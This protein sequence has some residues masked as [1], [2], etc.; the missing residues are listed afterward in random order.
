VPGKGSLGVGCLLAGMLLSGTSAHAQDA[1]VSALGL[2]SALGHNNGLNNPPG[3]L[4]P[5]QSHLGPVDFTLGA[6]AGVQANDNINLTQNDAQPDTII[7]AGMYLN[8]VWAAAE[9][10]ELSFNISAGYA[11]YLA[12]P[13][14]DQASI[15]PGSVLSWK[16]SFE[17]GSLTFFDQFSDSQAVIT[18]ASVSGVGTLPRIDNTIGT[19]AEWQPGRWLFDLGYSH[20]NFFSDDAAYQYLNR[21]SEYFFL[22]G[23][24]RLVEDTQLGLEASAGF[25]TYEQAIQSNNRNFSAG[26]YLE[27]QLTHFLNVSARGGYTL[28]VFDA[29]SGGQAAQNLNSYYINLNLTHQLTQSISQTLSVARDISPGFN[30]GNNYT[31]QL[32]ASYSVNWQATDHLG[33]LLNLTYEDGNQPLTSEIN[34]PLGPLLFSQTEDYS[35]VG[36][37]PAISY[38]FTHKLAGTLTGAHWERMSNLNESYQNNTLTVQLNYTF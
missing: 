26:P 16:I 22:R 20:D 34:T 29:N 1:L 30:R 25:T 37:S 31:E 21:A 18:E 10:S 15:A 24:H 27:W 7:N 13:V 35:R 4:L 6:S 33:L 14:N 36:I 17:D 38:Q 5:P 3:G 9:Q 28:Y 11:K 19:R 32:T 23:A 2:D 8:L 12:H